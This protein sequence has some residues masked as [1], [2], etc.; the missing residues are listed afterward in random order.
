[1]RGGTFNLLTGRDPDVVRKEVKFILKKFDLDF[2]CVQEST[3]YQKTLH[4]IPGYSYYTGGSVNGGAATEIGILVRDD[5]LVTNVNNRAYGDGWLGVG[6]GDIRMLPRNF[7]ILT[8]D[9]L[10]R[11]GN[12]HFPPGTDLVNASPKDRYEDYAAL[13]KRILRFLSGPS[14]KKRIVC[15]DANCPPYVRARYSPRWIANQTGATLSAPDDRIDY[16]LTKG[17]IV[18]KIKKINPEFSREKSDHNLVIF[19]VRP[20]KKKRRKS[21][22]A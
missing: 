11:V 5:H 4:D 22:A 17:L 19:V 6:W 8:I 21:K 16:I 3:K 18:D 14:R 15:M 12:C 9:G 20:R 1:M 10:F 7:L 2:L 13:S